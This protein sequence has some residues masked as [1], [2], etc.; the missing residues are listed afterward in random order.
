[1]FESIERVYKKFSAIDHLTF[2]DDMDSSGNTEKVGG[3]SYVGGVI[4]TESTS[5][6]IEKYAKSVKEYAI[7]RGLSGYSEVVANMVN[8]G[9]TSTEII[10]AGIEFLSKAQGVAIGTQTFDMKKLIKD[11]KEDIHRRIN[12][13][14]QGK[15]ISLGFPQIDRM[16]GG[17]RPMLIE[18]AGLPSTGKTDKTLNI[19]YKMANMGIPV[20]YI[21]AEMGNNEMMARICG[22]GL[23]ID[24]GSITNADMNDSEWA[25]MSNTNAL[26]NLPIYM[27]F[28]SKP[29][30]NMIRAKLM[31]MKATY[32]I[33]VAIVDH[34]QMLSWHTGLKSENANWR[35]I[36]KAMKIISRDLEMPVILAAQLSREVAR[37]KRAPVLSDL[38]EAGEED[39]D[40]VI[41]LH[42]EDYQTKETSG[43]LEVYIRK[44]RGGQTGM[45]T[46]WYDRTTGVIGE[47]E[48]NPNTIKNAPELDYSHRDGTRDP[49]VPF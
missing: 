28:T 43:Q 48:Y 5:A 18:I 12:E 30:A 32:G 42:R 41:M 40:V 16:I 24:R 6:G 38:R 23:E 2:L 44:A 36:P 3:D 37:A 8:E 11:G 33:K 45:V 17:L 26:E 7:K 39:A 10:S 31:S 46:C 19:M 35:E 34:M 14:A 29:N 13:R 21:S 4:A 47:E 1:M 15:G 27:D 22:I 20:G 49:D 9:K 25:A